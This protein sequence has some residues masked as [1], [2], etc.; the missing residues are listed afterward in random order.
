MNHTGG[1]SPRV[2]IQIPLNTR[3]FLLRVEG[4]RNLTSLRCPGHPSFL[5]G[6]PADAEPPFEANGRTTT[7]PTVS[8]PTNPAS[9]AL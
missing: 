9:M 3:Q 1:R 8:Q 7:N 5:A 4:F 2:R 6:E